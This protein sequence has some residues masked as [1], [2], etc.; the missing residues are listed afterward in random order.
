METH[1]AATTLQKTPSGEFERTPDLCLKDWD[2]G[3]E[4]SW[5]EEM[6]EATGRRW[7][8]TRLRPRRAPG[9]KSLAPRRPR[10]RSSLE[11]RLKAQ[12]LQ[13]GGRGSRPSFPGVCFLTSLPG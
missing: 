1:N 6:N 12:L 7:E 13:L 11:Q 2:T 5:L 10:G 8:G 9:V 4:L 3:A